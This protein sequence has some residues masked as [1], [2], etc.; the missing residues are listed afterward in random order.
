[1]KAELG[2]YY[3]TDMIVAT[4]DMALN[5]SGLTAFW[6]NHSPYDAGNTTSLTIHSRTYPETEGIHTL[7]RHPLHI[8]SALSHKVRMSYE[9]PSAN[10]RGRPNPHNGVSFGLTPRNPTNLGHFLNVEQFTNCE[11]NLP[12][13]HNSEKLIA[14]DAGCS[15]IFL[16]A[17]FSLGLFSC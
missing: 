5:L 17:V 1:M 2:R 12:L 14:L 10:V 15:P 3:K 13:P 11:G 8:A 6:N 9:L 7:P 16:R 4:L